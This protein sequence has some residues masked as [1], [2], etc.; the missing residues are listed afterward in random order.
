MNYE[1]IKHGD[2]NIFKAKVEDIN[3]E[4]LLK[5]IY[6]NKR[7][8]FEDREY[9]DE[10][11]F[12]PGLQLNTDIQISKHINII[13]QKSYDVSLNIYTQEFPNEKIYSSFMSTWVYI[14]TQSNP[15]SAYHDHVM[16]S[17]INHLP[18]TYTWVYYIQTPNNCTGDEG[19]IYFK[20]P[21]DYTKDDSNTL[22]F[23]P[24]EGYL[25]MWDSILGHKPALSPNSTIDRVIIAGN[26]CL[27]T[28]T[29]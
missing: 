17:N 8:L 29:L 28:S 7:F 24:E 18:T 3:K 23:F 26:V 22:K 16:L 21:Y 2:I 13:K 5:E 10:K 25:Y 20:Q 9:N 27:N 1:V 12:L 6:T 15:T 19:K 11:T 4:E 14:S